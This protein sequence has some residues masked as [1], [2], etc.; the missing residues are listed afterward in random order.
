MRKSE[1]RYPKSSASSLIFSA[2]SA[3][4]GLSF[5]RALSV[6]FFVSSH[7]NGAFSRSWRGG[8]EEEVRDEW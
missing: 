6:A 3:C 1:T 8:G 7:W 5:S 2:C 4:N